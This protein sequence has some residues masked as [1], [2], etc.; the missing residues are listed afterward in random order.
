MIQDSLGRSFKTLRISLTSACNFSCV[1]CVNGKEE[2]PVNSK[3][4]LKADELIS[5]VNNLKNSC[6][7]ETIRLTGGEPLL[8]KDIEKLVS[9]LYRPGVKIKLTTNAYFLKDKIEALHEAGLS[10]INVSMDSADGESFF[11]MTRNK[12]FDK[13]VEGIDKALQLGIEVKMNSVIVRGKNENQIL[14]LLEF[15]GKRRIPVRFLELMK[16]GFYESDHIPALF[17]ESD[18]LKVIES[19]YS[20][21]PLPRSVGATAKYWLT[22]NMLQFGII[23]NHSDPFCG[24]CDRLRLDSFGNIYGCLSAGVG[25]SVKDAGMDEINKKIHIALSQKKTSFTGSSMSMKYIGG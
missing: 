19:K 16:M 18:I 15:S 21:Y 22:D 12:S 20:V 11:K 24:D 17:T 13:V 23:S 9:G 4:P 2:K 7:L 6:N 5:I 10:S 25:V 8:Y 1:Y 14:P 3:I